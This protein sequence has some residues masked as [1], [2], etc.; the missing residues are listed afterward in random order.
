M[1]KVLVVMERK[2]TWEK[3]GVVIEWEHLTWE[4]MVIEMEVRTVEMKVRMMM[5]MELRM[6]EMKGRTVMEMK[7]EMKVTMVIETEVMAM[8]TEAEVIAVETKAEVMAVET[9][10]MT[11]AVSD[12]DDIPTFA[13]NVGVVPDMTGKEPVDYCQLFVS[14]S[15]LHNVLE[16]S[17]RYGDQYVESHQDHL[18]SYMILSKGIFP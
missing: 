8:E 6:V 15:I 2:I 4:R 11:M 18:Q 3:Y 17:N 1:K 7:T 14:D 5:E 16:E 12:G 13:E 9:G 10:V